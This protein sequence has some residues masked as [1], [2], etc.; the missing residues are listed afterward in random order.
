MDIQSVLEFSIEP[1][2]N[3]S[4]TSYTYLFETLSNVQQYYKLAKDVGVKG[5]CEVVKYKVRMSLMEFLDI[6]TGIE[7][8]PGTTEYIVSY[9]SK[10]RKYNILLN[11]KCRRPVNKVV[12]AVC[13]EKDVT[14]ELKV[15]FGP[16]YDFHGSKVT[17]KSL[18]YNDSLWISLK[19]GRNLEF[20][21]DQV[22][23]F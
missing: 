15:W 1:I 9:E 3:I 13:A 6:E 2:K 19:D 18:G 4:I 23:E 8:R 11:K 20:L 7:G 5:T 10:G 16:Y 14:S 12:L 22:I 21:S 17:P